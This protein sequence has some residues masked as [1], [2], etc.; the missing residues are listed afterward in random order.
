MRTFDREQSEGGLNK[1]KWS[2]YEI[3][4]TAA[5]AC[6]FFFYFDDNFFCAALGFYVCIYRLEFLCSFVQTQQFEYRNNNFRVGIL[7]C[8]YR[9]KFYFSSEH[10]ETIKLNISQK[11]SIK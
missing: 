6:E 3:F 10:P 2:T 4:T 8:L 5:A 1:K 9:N 7:I 11:V